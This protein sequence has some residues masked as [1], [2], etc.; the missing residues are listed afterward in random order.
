MACYAMLARWLGRST[1][2]VGS[3]TAGGNTRGV[4]CNQ[5]GL[6][7]F[8]VL[9]AGQG[10]SLIGSAIASLALSIWLWRTTQNATAMSVAT[11]AY[12]L[13]QVLLS[14]IAGTFV[15]RWGPRRTLLTESGGA[16]AASVSALALVLS[17]ALLAWQLYVLYCIAGAYSV[18]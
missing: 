16:A 11:I 18:F 5:A 13:P 3:R 1:W 7:G 8:S 10:V 2:T 15:D 17:R 4:K 9:V 14:P 6:A 12:L